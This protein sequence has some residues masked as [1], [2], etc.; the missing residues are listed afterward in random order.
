VQDT[1]YL[2]ILSIGGECTSE[3]REDGF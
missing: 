2:T 3:S 1:G